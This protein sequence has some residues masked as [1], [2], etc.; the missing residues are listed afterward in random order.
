ML[1]MTNIILIYIKKICLIFIINI[2]VKMILIGKIMIKELL[3]SNR[4]I[5]K[6]LKITLV[7]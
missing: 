7:L 6:F 3:I 5:A 2:V 1:I 4:N